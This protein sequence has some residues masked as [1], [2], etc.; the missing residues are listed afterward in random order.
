M[1]PR[2][3][4]RPRRWRRPACGTSSSTTRRRS[5]RFRATGAGAQ[6][7]GGRQG[8]R[9]GPRGRAA[10]RRS[11]ASVRRCCTAAAA[12]WWRS[13]RRRATRAAGRSACGTRRT[14]AESLGTVGWKTRRFGTSAATFQFFKYNEQK[15]RPPARPPGRR[16]GGRD[17]TAGVVA[18]TAAEADALSTALFVL[19]PAAA[20]RLTRLRPWTGAVV[21]AEGLC[22]RYFLRGG[23]LYLSPPLSKGGQGGRGLL[24]SGTVQGSGLAKTPPDPP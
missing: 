5:V 11:G 4:S 17:R 24:P 22:L 8:L 12:A 16:P 7:R 18:P 9:P 6:L 14:T 2:R 21:L 10:A 15:I 23:R 3:G 1:P 13:A 20:D 19:G